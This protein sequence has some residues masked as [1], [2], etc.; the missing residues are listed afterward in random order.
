MEL[1]NRH[2]HGTPANATYIGRGSPLGNLKV[3]DKEV[4][5]DQA[6]E[7]YKGWLK[8]KL[9]QRDPHVEGAFRNLRDCSRLLCFCR[10]R[11]C[12]GQVIAD[13]WAEINQYGSYEEGLIEFT[14]KHNKGVHYTP[15]M[16]GINHINV[17]S[18]S[19]TDL[20]RQLSNFAH[21]PFMHPEH[22]RFESIEAYWYWQA[23]G[24]QH[25]ALKA[26][27]GYEAKKLGK[28]FPRMQ[29]QGFIV[30]IKEAL[31]LKFEQNEQLALRFKATQLPLTHYYFFGDATN[32]KIVHDA[33]SAW[34]VQY[35]ELIRKY[36]QG[37]A[38]KV[39]IAGSR[40]VE[41]LQTVK[42][43]Y[44]DSGFEAVEIVSGHARGVDRLGEKV[45]E[46]NE[47]PVKMFFPD[48][49]TQGKAAGMIRNRAMGDYATALVAVWDGRSKGT[50]YM[51]EYMKSLNKPV[52]VHMGTE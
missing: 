14:R 8:D 1:L 23:T 19:M 17:Y 26:L 32:A 36:L 10:P 49:D 6:I 31:I 35:L 3:I 44:K 47:L 16:D 46:Q 22:G 39:I 5:R 40:G 18:K 30:K 37:N 13:Y 4:T 9:I 7:W 29:I 25:G 20:G 52:H 24:Q 45:A 51:I 48:W 41:D 21:T 33:K 15:D 38:H 43:A 50:K 11:P 34:L 27:Y 42:T 12:H 2:I 28:Q